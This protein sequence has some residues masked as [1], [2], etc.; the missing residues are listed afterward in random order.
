ML[1]KEGLIKCTVIHPKRFYHPVLRFRCNKEASFCL[2]NT[3]AF[4]CNFSD[5]CV[6]ESTAQRS[7]TSTWVLN[8]VRLAIQDG[9]EVLDSMELYEY[10]VTKNDPHTSEG[11]LFA[12]FINTF[13]KLKVEASRYHS[14]VLNGDDE[15]RY[16]ETLNAG[17]GLLMDSG[18]R[19]QIAAKRVLA[20][21]F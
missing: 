7:L 1:I 21:F 9:Y 11:G 3:Y 16:V 14:S 5:E 8:E 4:E 20:K 12:D 6:H 2:C 17:E 13:L 10:E 19:I 18:A 15:D